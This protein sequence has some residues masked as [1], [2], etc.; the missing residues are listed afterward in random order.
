MRQLFYSITKKDKGLLQ[1]TWDFLLQNARV[2]SQVRQLLKDTFI[3]KHVGTDMYLLR[4]KFRDLGHNIIKKPSTDQN[5]AEYG[6]F[7]RSEQH[8]TTH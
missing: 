3:T 1:N 2:L 7:S 6:L 8:V 5:N 4:Q